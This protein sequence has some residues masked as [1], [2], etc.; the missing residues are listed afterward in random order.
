MLT[1]G[2]ALLVVDVQAGFLPGE[3]L[4][5]PHGDEVVAGLSRCTAVF[6]SLP[7]VATR[8]RHPPNHPKNRRPG[9]KSPARERQDRTNTWPIQAARWATGYGVTARFRVNCLS[10]AKTTTWFLPK[11]FAHFGQ[12]A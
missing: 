8:D 10:L 11:S 9:Q 6:A 4:A 2:D 5:V 7:I 3:S 1:P 12:V